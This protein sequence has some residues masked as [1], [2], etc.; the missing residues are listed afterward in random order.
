MASVL[1][2][3]SKAIFEQTARGLGVGDI[4]PLASYDSDPKPFEALANGGRLYVVTARPGDQLWLVAVLDA[5]KRSRGTW[6]AA[7][8]TTPITDLTSLVTKLKFESGHGIHAKRGQLG[9]SL[10][11]PRALTDADTAL[12]DKRLPRPG[13]VKADA[14]AAKATVRP[15]LEKQLAAGN[16]D[17]FLVYADFLQE[18]GDPRGEL[19]H[20]HAKGKTTAA[21]ALLKKHADTL[22]GPLAKHQKHLTWKLGFIDAAKITGAPRGVVESI[23]DHESMKFVRALELEVAYSAAPLVAQ[24]IGATPRPALR[25]LAFVQRY[26]GFQEEAGMRALLQHPQHKQQDVMWK[27]LPKLES[28]RLQGWDLFHS[29]ALPEIRELSVTGYPLCTVPLDLPKLEKLSWQLDVDDTGTGVDW[30]TDAIALA[31]TSKTP[32]LRVLDLS[33]CSSVGGLDAQAEGVFDDVDDYLVW[34]LRDDRRFMKFAKQL[35]ELLLPDERL[36]SKAAI[37]KWLTA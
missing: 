15:V 9:M 33:R 24:R 19:I 4:H 18:R 16:D 14:K 35:D 5:P 27:A 13:K 2:L 11:T 3:I 36:T 29:M 21:T 22:L 6:T 31:W 28:L 34:A 26:L 12:I 1:A 37:A 20:L 23:L 7:T 30:S 8:N 10:Q 32:K 25:S 17:D